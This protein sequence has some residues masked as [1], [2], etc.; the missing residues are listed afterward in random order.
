MAYLSFDIIRR[1]KDS[2]NWKALHSITEFGAIDTKVSH[3]R[4]STI[5]IRITSFDFEPKTALTLFLIEKRFIF[6]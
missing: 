2:A 6:A 1:P 4:L 3:V 5:F